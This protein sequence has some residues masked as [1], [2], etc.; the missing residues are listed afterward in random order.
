MKA[1]EILILFL[2]SGLSGHAIGN[3]GEKLGI[4]LWVSIILA[5]VFGWLLAG[6]Y[7]L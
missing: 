2:A 7:Q 3:I 5:G 4:P 1:L 6:T